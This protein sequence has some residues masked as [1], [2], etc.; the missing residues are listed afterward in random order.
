M[1][2]FRLDP[3]PDATQ[4]PPSTFY[5]LDDD[6][7]GLVRELPGSG[8]WVSVR[9]VLPAGAQELVTR[10]DVLDEVRD[11]L[12]VAKLSPV[13]RDRIHEALSALEGWPGWGR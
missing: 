5:L 12:D 4:D 1:L 9:S 13:A 2:V 7:R 8:E 3:H 10:S 6:G 11:A